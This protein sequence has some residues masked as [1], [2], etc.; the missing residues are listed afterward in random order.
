MRGLQRL[1]C[2]TLYGCPLRALPD[3]FGGLHNLDE[4]DIDLGANHRKPTISKLPDSFSKLSN[5]TFLRLKFF[6]DLQNLP[7]SIRGLQRLR[8][9]TL[10]WCPLQGLPYDFGQLHNLDKLDI[11]LDANHD[12]PTIFKLPSSLIKSSNLTVLKLT[13]FKDLQELLL[14]ITRLVILQLFKMAS[15]KVQSLPSYIKHST[16]LMVLR[17]EHM[18]LLQNL[19][20]SFSSF[21]RL[22]TLDLVYNR[23]LIELP[24]ALEK[25]K[26]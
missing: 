15:I 16:K 14:S 23:D 8:I 3:N 11:D 6:E 21:K 9:L 20:D 18:N 26:L 12:K 25:C 19:P 24:K 2:L 4:L 10:H 13:N 17:L 5:L 22:N 1:R 7:S